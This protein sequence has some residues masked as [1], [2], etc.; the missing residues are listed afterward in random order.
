MTRRIGG[1]FR[2][3]LREVPNITNIIDPKC[4][5]I[6]L[7]TTDKMINE[8]CNIIRGGNITP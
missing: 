7:L 6:V 4:P 5:R 8:K 3:S 1:V 2:I